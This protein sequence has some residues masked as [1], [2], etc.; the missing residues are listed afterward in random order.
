MC[1]RESEK[2]WMNNYINVKWSLEIKKQ[3]KGENSLFFKKENVT[4]HLQMLALYD[5]KKLYI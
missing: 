3:K 2:K 5:L 4:E 1:E